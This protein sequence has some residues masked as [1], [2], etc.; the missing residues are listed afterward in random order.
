M[1]LIYNGLERKWFLELK[2][3]P[4]NFECMPPCPYAPPF[5]GVGV[6]GGYVGGLR[7]YPTIPPFVIL[8]GYLQ[9][10]Y[11]LLVYQVNPYKYY[12]NLP[13]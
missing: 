5:L 10:L 6:T 2:K 12:L 3:S 11:P 1:C 9:T 7:A 8:R 13:P 4:K